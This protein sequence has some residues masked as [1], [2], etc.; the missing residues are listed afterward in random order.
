MIFDICHMIK[1]KRNLLC[2]YHTICHIEN[3]HLK[4]IKWQFIHS[5][6]KLQEEIGFSFANKLQQKHLLWEKHKM[7]VKLTAQTLGVSIANVGISS[8]L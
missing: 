7:N 5:L 2:D 8:L 6:N 3:G 4:Q 1:L